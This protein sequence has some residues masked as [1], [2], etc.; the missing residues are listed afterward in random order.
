MGKS[1]YSF[2]QKRQ[3][4]GADSAT[5]YLRLTDNKKVFPILFG[6]RDIGRVFCLLLW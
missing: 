6:Q 3:T 4:D 1:L 5:V 2:T